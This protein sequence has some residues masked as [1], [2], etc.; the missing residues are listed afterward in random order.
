MTPWTRVV[1]KL[2]DGQLVTNPPL[3]NP[4]IH[5]RIQKIHS[6]VPILIQIIQSTPYHP[7]SV[8]F[9]LILSFLLHA[10]LQSDQEMHMRYWW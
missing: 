4:K 9:I 10:G 1:E 7:N 5:C 6:P 3:Y 8:R 2:I